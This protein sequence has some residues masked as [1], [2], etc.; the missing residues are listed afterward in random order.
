MQHF[1]IN[2]IKGWDRFYRANFINSLQ[3]FKPVS[4]IGT[5]NETGQSNLAIFSNIVHIGADPAL[6]GFINR[7]VAAAPHTIQNIEATREYTINHI[8]PSFVAAAHQTS[9]KYPAGTA[10][11]AAVGLTPVF[12][13]NCKAPFVGESASRYGLQLV[14]IVPIAY[15]KTFL[16]IGTITS[17]Y[18]EEG[19]V[20]QDG[21]ID[22]AKAK[23][24][25]SLGIDAYYAA[26]LIGSYAYAKPGKEATEISR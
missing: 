17:V 16:V 12:M 20:E 10:E 3:G 26:E 13:E 8:Q 19:L 1:S 15:N 22:A 5:V 23:S 4:L 25:A 2:E 14:E 9:A 24:V 11:F 21:F 18:L 7:P 6:I